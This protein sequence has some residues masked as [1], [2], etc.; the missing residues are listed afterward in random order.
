MAPSRTP[1]PY[2]LTD[3][4]NGNTKAT[5]SVPSDIAPLLVRF[6]I[7]VQGQPFEISTCAEGTFCVFFS[8]TP[9][10]TADAIGIRLASRLEDP[11][12]NEAAATENCVLS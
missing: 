4:P 2:I 6:P 9:Q 1:V 11:S 3:L 8:P 12:S 10:A 7:I 5:Y